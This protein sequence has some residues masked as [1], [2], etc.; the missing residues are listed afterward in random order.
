MNKDDLWKLF[1][2]TGNINYFIK[3]KN[4]I[5]EGIDYIGDNKS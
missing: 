5:Q 4:M 3:Y 2:I 1:T